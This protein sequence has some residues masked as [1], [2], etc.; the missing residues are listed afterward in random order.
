MK[1]EF[2]FHLLPLA[3]HV[4]LNTLY[5]LSELSYQSYHENFALHGGYEK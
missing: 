3:S 4:T 1:S 5:K 2:K